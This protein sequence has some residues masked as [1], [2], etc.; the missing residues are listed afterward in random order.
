MIFLLFSALLYTTCGRQITSPAEHEVDVFNIPADS[1]D[2]EIMEFA[3]GPGK[4][5]FIDMTQFKKVVADIPYAN[6][7]KSQVLDIV[8]PDKGTPP[9]PVIVIIHGG[10]WTGGDRRSSTLSAIF[11]AS[12]QG[13]AIA[14]IGYRLSSEALWPAQLHDAKA[15]I[16]FLRAHAAKYQLKTEN[17]LVWG[18]SSGAHIAQMMAGTNNRLEFED[19][20]MGNEH[21]S[22][23]IQGVISWYGISNLAGL[24]QA[25]TDAADKVMGYAVRENPERAAIASPISYVDEAFP[26]ILLVHGTA[27]G[28]VPYRQ[29]VR[30]YNRLTELAGNDKATLK[31]IEGARHGDPEI[32]SDKH[33]HEYLDFADL[34][35]WSGKNPYRG[36]Q[37]RD[38][39]VIYQ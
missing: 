9:Y 26:P 35:L 29:S 11:K 7:S 23:A 27:D 31:L 22:S 16:R 28:I 30:L 39:L 3:A 34:I 10:G 5:T 18:I 15:A 13:Y 33:I 4:G 38:I 36:K 37:L 2:M 8:Y 24:T 19:L 1:V 32:Q 14:T 25:G 6:Q 17:I 20:S 21:E 12:S